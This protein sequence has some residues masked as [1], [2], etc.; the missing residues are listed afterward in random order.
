MA[1]FAL[2]VAAELTDPFNPGTAETLF[3]ISPLVIGIS[4]VVTGAAVLRAQ[5]WTGWR[6]FVPV[7]CGV[8]VFAVFLP[9]VIT[10][11]DPGLWS[12][13]AG[14]EL[15]FAALGLAVVMEASTTSGAR[16]GDR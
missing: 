7:V 3:S 15:S 16:V 10:L 2:L 11:G 1:G 4:M 5:R 6:R 8:Y 12:A 14:W 13:L 9:L